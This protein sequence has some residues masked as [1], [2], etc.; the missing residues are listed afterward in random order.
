MRKASFF[1]GLLAVGLRLLAFEVGLLA[2]W[3]WILAV[4]SGLLAVVP[5]ILAQP[6]NLMFFN[7]GRLFAQAK[8]FLFRFYLR[9][10]CSYSLS[11]WI[12]SRS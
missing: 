9:S 11:R 10:D 7:K 1:G 5:G 4:D 12:Y 6:D 2:E 3:D 8:S